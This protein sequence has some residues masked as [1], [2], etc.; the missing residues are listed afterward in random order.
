MQFVLFLWATHLALLPV[1]VFDSGKP[2]PS[3][4]LLLVTLVATWMLSTP[5]LS[6]ARK[7][8][9]LRA[10]IRAKSRMLLTIF[11]VFVGYMSL[12][13]STWALLLSSFEP[14]VAISYQAFNLLVVYVACKLAATDYREFARYTYLG[15]LSAMLLI[16]GSLALGGVSSATRESGLFNNPNQLAYFCLSTC[17]VMYMAERLRIAS[18]SWSRIV[19][20]LACFACGLSQSRAGVVCCVAILLACMLDGSGRRGRGSVSKLMIGVMVALMFVVTFSGLDLM[21][22]IEERQERTS[23]MAISEFEAR[24]Y[25]R[26]LA[27]PEYLLLG[28]GEG[29]NKRFGGLLAGIGGELHSSLGTLVFCY[30]VI[31]F[32]IY[33]TL[34]FQMVTASPGWLLKLCALMP[35]V[36]ALTHNG[37]RFPAAIIALVFMTLGG[38]A[39]RLENRAPARRHFA[40]KV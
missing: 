34:W 40:L 13:N 35:I 36:Y 21:G 6:S 24:G 11:A 29:E 3:H 19:I 7:S 2:Q 37:L 23:A 4:F 33:S 1:Y 12:V 28:A 27:H 32:I 15:F 5:T 10:M 18:P 8:D 14:L 30:G 9:G 16:T 22:K 17:M 39:L 31:G 38:Y 26:I 25:D 20:G